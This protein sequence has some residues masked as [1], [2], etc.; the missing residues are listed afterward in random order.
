MFVEKKF[1]AAIIG[2]GRIGSEFD[3][4]PKRK[5]IT[6]HAGGYSNNP[7]IELVAVAD[8]D[9]QKLEKCKK[10]W[11]VPN[12][13]T[14]YKEMLEKEN[15]DILSICTWS[16][17]HHTFVLE[18]VK[19]GVKAIFCE[20]PISDSLEN[21]EKMVNECKQNN[22]LLFVD[23]GRRFDSFHRQIRE[24]VKN[25]KLG[26]I[27]QAHFYYVA[28]I[29]NSGSHMLDL[30][31]YFLGDVEW[32][33]GV[34]SSNKSPNEKDPNIDAMIKFKNGTMAVI[35]ACDVKSF[36]VFEPELIGT[37][38]RLRI[39]HCGFNVEYY[40][41]KESHRFSGYNEPY[42]VK[43]DLV[44][45]E[46]KFMENA[47]THIV[48]V[49]NNKESNVSSGDDGYKSLELINA[50][51]ESAEQDGKRIIFPLEKKDRKIDS[52]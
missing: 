51:L 39:V 18:A 45:P 22:V 49:L 52:R 42:P 24:F 47:I 50:M 28:G 37:K 30:L 8:L 36:M 38:G 32:V 35:Q 26:K 7:D 5:T 4:D 6:S 15:L 19:H 11:N 40:E 29:A 1:R 46:G 14:D 41:V 25:E 20:K 34:Y 27:Q 43:L 44:E 13:Y 48:D 3:D 16:S 17:T 31:R 9:E 12:I 2:C 33:S 21:A 23:H 10:R